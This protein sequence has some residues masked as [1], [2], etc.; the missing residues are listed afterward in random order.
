MNE[1][2]MTWYKTVHMAR[3][4][5]AVLATDEKDAAAKFE[6]GFLKRWNVSTGR[7]NN[8]V[9][10]A[11]KMPTSKRSKPKFIEDYSFERAGGDL[12]VWLE[13]VGNEPVVIFPAVSRMCVSGGWL[14]GSTVGVQFVPVEHTDSLV[15]L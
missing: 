12:L 3:Q 14:Y 9:P 5:Y 7:G 13:Q 11:R 1:Q 15:I 2:T 6:A 4:N 10:L 8:E